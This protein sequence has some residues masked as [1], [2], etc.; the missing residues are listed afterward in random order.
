MRGTALYRGDH[1]PRHRFPLVPPA[2]PAARRRAKFRYDLR[3]QPDGGA[4]WSVSMKRSLA[5]A[6]GDDELGRRTVLLMQHALEAGTYSNYESNLR[7]FWDFCAEFGLSPLDVTPVLIARY[8]AWIGN[9]GTVAST[10]LQ[11]YL[12]AINRLLQDHGR[13]PVALGP[14]VTAVRRG[15]AHCQVD[16]EP[17][18]VRVPLPAPVA[19]DILALGEALST[20][21]HW[22]TSDNMDD[23][24]LLRACCAS[25]LAY[26]FFNRGECG[27]KLLRE[28]LVVDDSHITL[29]LRDAKGK[30]TLLHHQRDI[31]QLSAPALPRVAAL[32][33]AYMRGAAQLGY[34]RLWALSGAEDSAP[35]TAGTVTAWLQLAFLQ[36]GHLPPA[37][38]QWT[39]HSLRKGAASAAYAIGV[40]LSTI[41]F[42]GGWAVASQVLEKTYIDYAMTSTPAAVLFF[43]HLLPR[44]LHP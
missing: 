16:L 28:D 38:F 8:V 23:R 4:P 25:V 37:G 35:W 33:R 36:A 41:R 39:S 32:L 42:M 5:P 17:R 22:D 31:R 21:V 34:A 26:L 1:L 12:S 30:K 19:L 44:T 3:F 10:S 6:F 2:A 18:D 27:A 29:L 24:L 43:A 40:V 11:P 15:L 7:H 20:R 14:V 13:E 9:K